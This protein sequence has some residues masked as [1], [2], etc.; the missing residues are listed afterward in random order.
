MKSCKNCYAA[1]TGTHPLQGKPYG[2]VLGYKTDGAG[3]AVEICPK[4]KSWK[5]LF[6]L[7]K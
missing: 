7:Q 4:P 3:K 2:C 6:R 1:Q 5:E